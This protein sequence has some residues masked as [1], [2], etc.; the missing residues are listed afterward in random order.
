MP[1][2]L[3]LTSTGGRRPPSPA[4]RRCGAG[5]RVV[6]GVGQHVADRLAQP[7]LVADQLGVAARAEARSASRG[8]A[9]AWSATISASTPPGRTAACSSGRPWSRFASSSRSSTS[10]PIRSASASIRAIASARSSGRSAAPRRNSSANPRT[11]VSGVR[12]SCEASATNRRSRCSDWRRSLEGLLDLGQHRVQ[13][14]G[15]G[16]PTSVPGRL[17]DTRCVRSP[18]AIAAAVSSIRSSGRS[19]RRTSR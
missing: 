17:L 11:D 19:S 10:T 4:P 18:P 14:A 1:G 5:R 8:A 9:C 3:S 16:S 6:A 7:Q 2:P 15:R 12:S 13:R